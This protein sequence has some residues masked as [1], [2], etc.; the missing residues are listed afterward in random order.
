MKKLVTFGLDGTLAQT[1]SPLDDE[2]AER[3]TGVLSIVDVAV[4]SGGAWPQFEK[5]V[6]A[7][8]P[9]HAKLEQLSILPACGT[10]F[11]R[12]I[13]EWTPI[14]SEDFDAAQKAKIISAL[15]NAIHVTE[16]EVEN[17][18]GEPLEDRGSQITFSGLASQ[19]SDR[20][21]RK[22]GS[23]LHQAK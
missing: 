3:L 7:Q 13:G 6:L 12:F 11:Y 10:K 14:D 17:V 16:T 8:L 15:G 22:V 2:M 1:K 18:W 9:D 21:E 23:E 4:I 20:R 19:G 5:Q